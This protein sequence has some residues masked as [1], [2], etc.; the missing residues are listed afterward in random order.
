MSE[1]IELM[2]IA[3]SRFGRDF[4]TLTATGAGL[5]H[6]RP[7]DLAPWIGEYNFTYDNVSARGNEHRPGGYVNGNLRVARRFREIGTTTRAECPLSVF[8]VDEPLMRQLYL[9][10]HE[11]DVDKLLL[12]RLFPVGRGIFCADHIPTNAQYR[13]AIDFFREMEAK[14]KRPSVKLQCALRFFD[15]GNL[16]E[17]PCDLARES[18][19][20]MP[21]GTL[22]ASPWAYNDK[23]EPLGDEWVLGNLAQQP[24]QEILLSDKAQHFYKHIN[25]NFGHCKIFAWRHSALSNRLDRIFDTSDPLYNPASLANNLPASGN[26]RRTELA[27]ITNA[28]CGADCP[29]RPTGEENSN[30]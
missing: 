8:N 4:V 2:K 6:H 30:E 28:P 26:G 24:L 11:A 15:T 29:D 27:V 7:E 1:S 12:M 17:N 20:L 14:Y 19:G 16:R 5:V 21:D 22:L 25:D 10:L 18:F 13:F 3:A 9:D 23:G